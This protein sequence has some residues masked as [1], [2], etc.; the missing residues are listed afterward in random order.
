MKYARTAWKQERTSWRSVIQ[1]NLIRSVLT[2]L[3]T[4]QAEMD[5]APLMPPAPA[6]SLSIVPVPRSSSSS[7]GHGHNNG[8]GPSKITAAPYMSDADSTITE[9]DVPPPIPLGEHH[10]VLQRRLGPLRRVEADLKRRLG[11]GTE[12][13]VGVGGDVLAGAEA[14]PPRSREW[15]VRAWSQVI[16]GANAQA[17]QQLHED[18][19]MDEATEVIAGCK[20]DML[21]LW[22]DEDVQRVLSRRRMRV[23]DS[24]GL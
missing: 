4:L 15:G 21:A 24:A 8:H 1:L 23:E 18:A 14:E 9:G 7:S 3:E 5:N 2:I 6:P 20:D 17:G 10:R 13:V 19:A 12:E 16:S 11:A 22:T